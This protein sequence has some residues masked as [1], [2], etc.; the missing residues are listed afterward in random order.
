MASEFLNAFAKVL[1]QK[2]LDVKH[3][4]NYFVDCWSDFIAGCIE[5]YSY[6]LFDFDH[7]IWF[8]GQIAAIMDS[9]DL[10][11]FSEIQIFKSRI[12]ELDNKFKSITIDRPNRKHK[13]SL[14]WENKLLK[15]AA[16][17]YVKDVFT[18]YGLEI[19]PV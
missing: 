7:D 16:P 9:P 13:A 19:D 15:Y 2:E 12:D 10:Q 3:G 6:S 4:P 14:W 11:E 8:R 5:G 1:A 18:V 17:E